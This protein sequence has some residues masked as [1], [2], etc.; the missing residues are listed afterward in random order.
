MSQDALEWIAKVGCTGGPLMI[1]DRKHFPQW[2]GAIPFRVLRERSEADAVRFANR[3]TVLH[4]WGNLGG[5]GEQFV[6][7]DSEAEALAKLEG[8]HRLAKENC[9]GVV[10]TEEEGLTHFRDPASGGELRA[11]LEPKSEYD[12]SWQSNMDADAW[13]HTFGDDVRALFWFVGDDLVHVGCSKTGDEIVLLKHTVVS[14]ETRVDDHAAACA[15]VAAQSAGAR[16]AELALSTA[17][18]VVIWAP[19]AVS[20]LKGFD[21]REIAGGEDTESPQLGTDFDKGIGTVLRVK[22]GHYIASLGSV[23]P[24]ETENRRWSARWCRLTR[25]DQ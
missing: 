17:R 14:H 20:E 9:P 7:C 13:V 18:A 21:P 19:I 4:F 8:L 22:P 1:V 24:S 23:D 3:R 5:A 12:A 16:V 15:Y 10:I 25:T 2:T 6:E 11:E